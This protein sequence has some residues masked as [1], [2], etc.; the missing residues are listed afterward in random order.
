MKKGEISTAV[1]IGVVLTLI[2]T[3]ILFLLWGKLSPIAG[4]ENDRNICQLSILTRATTPDILQKNVPIK[5]TAEKICITTGDDCTQFVEESN[6]RKIK[7]N[8]S[9]I[10]ESAEKIEQITADAMY[11][12]WKITGEGKLDLFGESATLDLT[13][14]IENYLQLKQKGATCIVCSRVAL[15]E[16]LKKEE[17]IL[18]AVNINDYLENTLVPNSQKNYIET[19]TNSKLNSIPGDV[20]QKFSNTANSKEGTDQIAIIFAQVKTP[21]DPYTAFES[22]AIAG[23]TALFAGAYG[24]GGLGA[25]AKNPITTIGGGIV[26]AVTTGGL[27]AYGAA[28]QQEFSTGYCGKFTSS[29]KD[30]YGCSVI[31]QA[32]WNKKEEINDL[33]SGGIEGYA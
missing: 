9:K 20:K 23:G 1:I 18:K 29:E 21:N 24:F 19:F 22:G 3:A 6:V 26:A 13:D 5:C 7:L 14:N 11:D 31:T 17:N 12:C 8:P 30:R 28:S 4:E 27:K 25:L 15:S 33:C 10:E 2:A 16:E 32:D